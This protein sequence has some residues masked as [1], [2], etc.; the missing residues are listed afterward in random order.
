MTQPNVFW[1]LDSPLA[2]IVGLYTNVPEYGRLD[3]TQ[4][5]WLHE[6]LASAPRDRALLVTMHH[7]P[8]SADGYHS[9][10]APMMGYLD[11]AMRAT[12][13]IPELICAGHVHD[14]QRHT[15]DAAAVGGTGTITYVVA[16]HGGYHN[17][18]ALAPDVAGLALPAP[19]PGMSGVTIDAA[20]ASHYG[21]TRVRA[22]RSEVTLEAVRVAAPPGVAPAAITREVIDTVV[23]PLR[24]A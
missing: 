6:E 14:Y 15:R 3:A 22:T 21:Y 9:S 16:G 5:A 20:D 19:F 7:P 1:T 11:D 8:I 13:R 23:V 18:H 12:G 24:H 10:S 17:L 2:T 4:A